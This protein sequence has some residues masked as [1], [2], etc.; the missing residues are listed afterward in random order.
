MPYKPALLSALLLLG[1]LW[2]APA[3]VHAEHEEWPQ[4]LK[5]F[6][7][8]WRVDGLEDKG[9]RSK[10]RAQKR[11]A[12]KGLRKSHDAR[13]VPVFLAAHKKQQK[14]IRGLEKLWAQRRAKWEKLR[15]SMEKIIADAAKRQGV[16]PGGQVQVPAATVG[17]WQKEGHAI[18]N[19]MRDIAS[20]REIAE[21]TRKGMAR[22]CNTVAGKEQ[23]RAIAPLLKAAGNG[24][25]PEQR[26]FIRLLGYIQS[27]EVTDALTQLAADI[28][29]FVSATAL[30]ALGRQNA[31]RSIDVLLARLDDPRWQLRVASLQGLSFYKS[32]RV[33]DALLGR[34]PEEDGV[35]KRHYFTALSRIL[36][37]TLPTTIEAW[38]SWWKANRDATTKRWAEGD[39]DGPVKEDLPPVAL[40]SENNS[41]STSFYGLKTESKHIIFI[42]DVSGSMGEHGG[43]NE[44]GKYAID[45]A[46]RELTNAIKSLTAEE[47]DERGEAS[48]NVVAYAAEVRVFK[49]G[50]MM[51]ATRGNKD[52]VFKW[53]DNLEAIGAT[54]IFDAIEQAFEIID[55]RKA[56]KQFEKGADTIFLMTDG[57]PNRGKI[58]DP[59]LIREEVRKMNRERK[60]TIH[61]I[62]VGK[63]HAASFLKA[64]AAENNGEY[65]AR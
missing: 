39:Y 29:P 3:A 64:L 1:L 37:E 23:T 15:P 19:L 48:F 57:M 35:L 21:Y 22:V 49:S 31:E 36:N 58:T 61:T 26:E 34:L 42:I 47:G 10:L 62:G 51:P 7:D 59:V 52:K 18:E 60:L 28:Q 6:K 12:V 11:S 4:L 63:D 55:T 65:L 32:A 41:G 46:K 43:K 44:Q 9:L 56:K 45:I 27:D 50:K 38:T 40:K 2:Q 8:T 16:P 14:F 24:Q 33:V 20:E 25:K 30:E 54:N 5:A 13:A 17:V 53:I